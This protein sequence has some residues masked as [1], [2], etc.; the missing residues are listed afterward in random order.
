MEEMVMG[1]MGVV[2]IALLHK[3]MLMLIEYHAW[4]WFPELPPP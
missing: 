3:V 2:L 4:A 1:I